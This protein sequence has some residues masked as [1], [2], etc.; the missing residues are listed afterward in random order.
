MIPIT[1]F[2]YKCSYS[3]PYVSLFSPVSVSPRN[4]I[5]FRQDVGL[6][7]LPP[8]DL[9]D[10]HKNFEACVD[11]GNSQQKNT[12]CKNQLQ[13]QNFEKQQVFS[14]DT[15]QNS[16]N[17]I[18]TQKENPVILPCTNQYVNG[19]M[20]K[21]KNHIATLP[22]KY[23]FNESS[24]PKI[25]P[26]ADHNNLTPS[27]LPLSPQSSPIS[28]LSSL[29]FEFSQPLTT[30]SHQEEE[31]SSFEHFPINSSCPFAESSFN[32]SKSSYSKIYKKHSRNK[33]PL[34]ISHF[35]FPTLD[36]HREDINGRLLEGPN[37]PRIERRIK[38]VF[39]HFFVF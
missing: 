22:Q 21:E 15:M 20:L 25:V 23:L 5:P 27:S 19:E 4:T 11:V 18:E 29:S 17:K 36:I 35:H 3:I 9:I 37:K 8:S 2:P 31:D 38:Q 39:C 10:N 14:L 24:S 34:S 30:N 32:S 28:T 1:A 12:F 33:P 7:S 6:I 16:L 13:M 26:N